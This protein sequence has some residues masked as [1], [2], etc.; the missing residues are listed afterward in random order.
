MNSL[1]TLVLPYSCGVNDT[2]NCSGGEPWGGSTP[3][4][5]N[6][7]NSAP[8]SSENCACRSQTH[9]KKTR[10]NDTIHA[11]ERIWTTEHPKG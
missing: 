8:E 1:A 4:V 9:A 5:G 6:T 10:H 7:A 3:S 11:G 2:T